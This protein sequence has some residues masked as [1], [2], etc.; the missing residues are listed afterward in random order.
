MRNRPSRALIVGFAIGSMVAP[1]CEAV[2]QT[3]PAGAIDRIRP[4]ERRLE[5]PEL[6]PETPP[7]RFE[8]PPVP[9]APEQ[10]PLSRGPTFVLRGLRFEGNTVFTD[11]ELGRVV[12]PFIGR[13]VSTE[14][15][16]DIRR[17][18][19]RHYLD[20]GFINSGAIIP[21]QSV[22]GG[23]VAMTIIEGSLSDIDVEGTV[24]IHPDYIRDRVRLGA[25]P[26]LNVRD[27]QERVQL[28]LQDPLVRRVDVRLRPGTRLGDA[29]LR[30]DVEEEERFS[31]RFTFSNSR[32]PSVGSF[33]G[34]AD[35]EARN[36]TGWGD[37]HRLTYARTAGLEN[38]A[39][40]T[41]IPVNAHDT[42]IAFRFENSSS[43]VVEQPFNVID[44]ESESRDYELSV[45][46]PVYRTVSSKLTL[47]IEFAH[48]ESETFLL[49]IPFSFSPG[50]QDGRSKVRVF[51]FVQDWIE[52]TRDQVVAVRSSFN[53]GVDLFNATRNPSPTPDG[54]FFSWLGQAQWVRRV[55]DEIQLILRADAQFTPDRLL[56]LEKYA[57]GGVGSVRGYRENQ[58]VKDQGYT[59]SIEGR[60][61][62]LRAP[63]PWIGDAP[64]DGQVQLAPF[65]DYARAWDRD[66]DNT[67]PTKIY[68]VGLGLLWRIREDINASI[69]YGYPLK[70]VPDPGDHSLQD[71]GIHFRLT[72]GVF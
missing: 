43:E 17:R 41:G 69:Y 20:A 16:Q 65:F 34:R 39:F 2:A 33:E 56:P 10:A 47:G 30:V 7:P 1:L 35:V 3:P 5:P 11:E 25:G 54:T 8:L 24:H 71:D 46:H 19:S 61:P 52:R 59:L 14:Q 12:Q 22:E 70:D 36:F 21:D 58:L 42:K 66:V 44:V 29:K 31:S 32:P 27:L 45:T 23:I 40:R 26:P 63:V 72:A 38:V 68:S 57:A 62:V 49:G 67:S 18:L 48:R 4:S 13:R 15:L 37:E 28:L 51:R 6:R 60:I 9:P 50:P 55:V 64:E 53:Q